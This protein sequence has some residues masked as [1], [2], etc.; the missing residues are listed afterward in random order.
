MRPNP[1]IKV[2]AARAGC[3]RRARTSAT[4]SDPKSVAC[5]DEIQSSH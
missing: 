5:G 2:P 3:R 1:P 4:R